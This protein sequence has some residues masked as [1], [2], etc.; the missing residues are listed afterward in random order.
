VLA[1]LLPHADP[2]HKVSIL[3]R[4]LALG[5]TLQLPQEDRY[6][7]SRG[8]L[9]DRITV[10]LGGR[11]SE[12]LTFQEISTGAADDLKKATDMA[13][14]M[15]TDFGMSQVLGP[16]SLGR[17]HDQPFLG[18]DLMDDRNYS[19]QVASAIDKELSTIIED[20]YE[21][22]KA[23]LTE[24]GEEV[25]QVVSVLLERETLSGDEIRAVMRGEELP[26][27]RVEPQ[28]AE[29]EVKPAEEEAKPSVGGEQPQVA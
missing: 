10:F 20:C 18:R 13:R 9:L 11:V 17:K 15:V 6:I 3:Q 19:E 25:R 1:E 28:P 12:E 22:A 8:E 2:V 26:P 29:Q 23:L 7:M 21:R 14:R 5:Y 16:V 24:H 27:T 4:G